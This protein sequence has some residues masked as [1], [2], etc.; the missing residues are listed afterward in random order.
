MIVSSA[1]Q[2]RFHNITPDMIDVMVIEL[3]NLLHP[4]R[5]VKELVKQLAKRNN[6]GRPLA[7]VNGYPGAGK[8]SL[9]Q[10]FSS[11][12]YPQ[13][14]LFLETMPSH[15]NFSPFRRQIYFL[16]TSFLACTTENAIVDRGLRDHII[17]AMIHK[18]FGDISVVEECRCLQIYYMMEHLT[19][20][21]SMEINLNI[22]FDTAIK[23][24]DARKTKDGIFRTK[25]AFD[26]YHCFIIEVPWYPKTL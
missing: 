6:Y 23:R 16:L 12:I 24:M 20:K 3:S 15:T 25:E 2:T 10:Y 11:I 19:P 14:H 18:A 22:D 13:S 8:T 5:R 17:L 26:M 4:F 9:C 7:V 21:P 1:G